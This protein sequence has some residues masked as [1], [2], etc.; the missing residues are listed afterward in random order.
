MK[1]I[2]ESDKY[3]Q[4]EL[5]KNAKKGG[6]KVVIISIICLIVVVLFSR[7]PQGAMLYVLLTL[8]IFLLLFGILLIFMVNRAVKKAIK[9]SEENKTIF[10]SELDETSIYI[11]N[12][13][14]GEQVGSSK[15]YYKDLV[16]VVETA[17]YIFLY[18]NL[19]MAYP[20]S[21]KNMS[22]EDIATIKNWINIARVPK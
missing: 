12:I 9:N 16:K 1:N 10:E 19:Q 11:I 3:M 18:P 17:N 7:E 8:S 4:L 13:T 2:C 20:I 21:K 14:N 5:N 15:S 6:L 22:Q